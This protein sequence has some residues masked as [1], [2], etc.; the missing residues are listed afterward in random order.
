VKMAADIQELR[1]LIVRAAPDA[2]LARPVESCG[3][4]QPLDGVIPFSSVIV[5]GVVVA[6]E[7]RYGV[8]VTRERLAAVMAGGVTLRKLAAMIDAAVAEAG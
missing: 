3:A 8:R 5:L 1:A 7:D 6:V 2:A 4:D